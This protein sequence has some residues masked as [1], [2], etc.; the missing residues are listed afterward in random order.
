MSGKSRPESN[1]LTKRGSAKGSFRFSV[2]AF[3]SDLVGLTLTFLLAWVVRLGLWADPSLPVPYV[4][5]LILALIGYTFLSFSD[6]IYNIDVLKKSFYGIYSSVKTIVLMFGLLLLTSFVFKVTSEFS[7]I[8]AALWVFIFIGYVVVLRIIIARVF[9]KAAKRG[10][11]A[12]NVLIYG[13]DDKGM[14]LSRHLTQKVGQRF[15]LVGFIDD[16]KSRINASMLPSPLL[17]SLENVGDIIKDYDVKQVFLS[18]PNS[19]PDRLNNIT[20]VVSQWAVDVYAETALNSDIF[21]DSSYQSIEGHLFIVTARKPIDL[22]QAFTKR[23]E[24]LVIAFIVSVLIAPICLLVALAIKMES[25]GPVLFIQQRMGFNGKVIP[26][27]KF[28]SMYT[29]LSDA[30]AS[31]QTT[32]NDTRVTKIGKFIRR[33][34]IDELPQLLNVLKGDMSLVG[35]RPHALETKAAGRRFEDIV[36]RY[37]ARHKVKPGLT[38]WAQ[39]NGWRGE[40]DTEEKISRRVE[41][42]MYYINNWSIYLDLFI[43]AK[44]ALVV[45]KS[46]DNV[47]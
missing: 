5:A 33:T 47:Y 34:S 44:T 42:D 41:C 3:F 26:V 40:T 45:I 35:P 10:E 43:L 21:D 2:T 9:E 23:V 8:W 25:R 24:D 1:E 15:N 12:T 20:K 14:E 18:L 28:R 7:R 37:A 29:H 22:W 13:A 38:G 46:N 39:V 32:R 27:Y 16:R 11:T 4:Y 19:S 36:D 17:G 30:H 6:G 31:V